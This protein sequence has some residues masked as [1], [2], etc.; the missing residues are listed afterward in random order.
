M[1]IEYL[2]HLLQTLTLGLGDEEPN[3]DESNDAE[4]AKKDVSAKPG[5]LHER[6]GDEANDEVVDPVCF[7][8]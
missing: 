1:V 7:A 8:R 2:V 3:V 5:R 6:R 4:S